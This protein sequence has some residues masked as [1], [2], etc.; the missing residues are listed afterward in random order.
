MKIRANGPRRGWKGR[1]SGGCSR[2]AGLTEGMVVT[3]G[4]D[5]QWLLEA[6]HKLTEHVSREPKVPGSSEERK[7][8]DTL[9]LLIQM[10]S[11]ERALSWEE[12]WTR[13]FLSQSQWK[14]VAG[15]EL[16]PCLVESAGPG[17]TT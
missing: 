8:E 12:L 13:S 9:I 16:A 7:P 6:T 1:P 2:G 4:R 5:T 3:P 15:A 17:V 14:L 11:K 10:W